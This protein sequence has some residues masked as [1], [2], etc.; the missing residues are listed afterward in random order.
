MTR[1]TIGRTVC[2]VI[3]LAGA[4]IGCQPKPVDP[5]VTKFKFVPPAQTAQLRLD[6]TYDNTA[7]A[8][9]VTAII[10]GVREDDANSGIPSSVE[11]RLRVDNRGPA[12]V[13]I[14]P[15]TLDLRAGEF[16]QF[17]PAQ[18]EPSSTL[19]V[20]PSDSRQLTAYFPFP[21]GKTYDT[22]KL[23]EVRLSYVVKLDDQAFPETAVFNYLP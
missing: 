2:S 10:M 1:K 15:G 9:T 23:K 13:T 18:T 12:V 7:P 14:D 16:E 5:Y 4:L 11:V 6:R 8:A 17:P 22:T 20:H 19:E 21:N 3:L